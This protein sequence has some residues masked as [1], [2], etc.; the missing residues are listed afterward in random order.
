MYRD[1]ILDLIKIE[2][3]SLSILINARNQSAGFWMLHVTERLGKAA[4]CFLYPSIAIRDGLTHL[5][6]AA[7]VILLWVQNFINDHSE[8]EKVMVELTAVSMGFDP[9]GQS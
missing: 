8:H 5:I 1:A 2:H 9:E 6:Q 3:Q 7:A 4:L